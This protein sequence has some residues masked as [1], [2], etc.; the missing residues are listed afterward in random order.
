MAR[1]ILNRHSFPSVTNDHLLPL[2]PLRRRLNGGGRTLVALTFTALL[3][4]H[5]AFG[6][7]APQ[8]TGMAS[9]IAQLIAGKQHPLLHK[10]DLSGLAEELSRLYP[11]NTA[12][13]L[14]L[15]DNGSQAAVDAALTILK[16]AAD[17]GLNPADYDAAA[18]EQALRTAKTQALSDREQ[19]AYDTALSAAL[20]R[21]IHDLH[22]G[23][24]HPRIL[25]YPLEFGGKPRL[26]GAD[27]IKQAL[28]RQTLPQLPRQVEPT[29]AQY[30]QLKQ[31]L[32]GLRQLP[33]EAPFPALTLQKTLHSGDPYPQLAALQ[34][35]LIALG[36]WPQ[37][38]DAQQLPTDYSGPF[39]EGVQNFQRQHGLQADGILG[40]DTLALLNQ[41]RDQQISQIELTMERLRWLPETLSGPLIIVNI[42]AFELMA[43]HSL[44]DGQALSM[45]VIVG[46][47]EQNQTPVLFEDMQYL[48][49][50]PYWNI[51]RSILDKEIVPRM[52]DDLAFLQNQDIEL[53]QRPG[54]S[55]ESPLDMFADLSEGK[56]RARQRPG[57]RN[58]LGKVKFIFPNKEDVYLH[59][60][61]THALFDRSRRDFSHGCVRVAEA[62]KL[63]EFVLSYQSGWDKPAIEQAMAG[64]KT[65]RVK[66][67]QSIPVLFFYA[68]SFV[69]RDNR[70]HFYRDI[71][72][73]DEALKKALN[74][75][76][77][78]KNDSLI[79]GKNPSAG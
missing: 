54:S 17:S 41:T 51:P 9:D 70:L 59:D 2:F 64:S 35:R 26:N 42:P 24:I 73:Q 47:A 77:A 15:G 71:Y 12:S 19:A 38:I 16:N 72:N 53:V 76:D 18:L 75:T 32:A 30:Q 43:F 28:A 63:A 29:F 45:K 36:V 13:L 58:P 34:Q 11:A 78:P 23:R 3:L 67:T 10:T 44:E 79:S 31:A 8:R 74:K 49:F 20:L 55:S 48:E 1:L 5:G 46:K 4:T 27:V 66:L 22:E 37:T 56:I 69:D 57:S 68:T 65:Q 61:P 40:K 62:D 14:W 52:L 21:L 60:T 39:L 25:G 6:A 50:Q 33:K 7:D